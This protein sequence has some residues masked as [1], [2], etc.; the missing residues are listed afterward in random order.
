MEETTKRIIEEI[1]KDRSAAEEWRDSSEKFLS[2][3]MA[4]EGCDLNA[5]DENI[6]LLENLWENLL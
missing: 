4:L 3:A 5:N 2:A 1:G 6:E